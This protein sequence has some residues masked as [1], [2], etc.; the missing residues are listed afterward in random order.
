MVFVVGNV[1]WHI[2]NIVYMAMS[3]FF[4]IFTSGHLSD[5][6]ENIRL[7]QTTVESHKNM[8]GFKVSDIYDS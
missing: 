3:V 1:K 7:N 5:Q 6:Y 8:Y 2:V 4:I